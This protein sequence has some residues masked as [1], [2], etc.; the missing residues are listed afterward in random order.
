[1]AEVGGVFGSPGIPSPNTTLFGVLWPPSI[2]L[3]MGGP[4][5]YP[6]ACWCDQKHLQAPETPIYGKM[7]GLTVLSV[8]TMGIPRTKPPHTIFKFVWGLPGGTED[9]QM[10]VLD[11]LRRY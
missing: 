11:N 9:P 2:A 10:Q 5:C 4:R 1:M 8:L 7:V 6:T 3:Y